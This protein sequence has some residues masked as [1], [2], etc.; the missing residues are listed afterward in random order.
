MS[1]EAKGKWGNTGS[2][3]RKTQEKNM[4]NRPFLGPLM[5]HVLLV[6][7]RNFAAM[8]EFYLDGLNQGV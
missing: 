4:N 2:Y 3:Y 7:K 8:M 1:D 5:F 6:L